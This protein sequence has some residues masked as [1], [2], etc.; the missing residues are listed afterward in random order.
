VRKKIW[1][2]PFSSFL[3]FLELNRVRSSEKDWK[4]GM[5]EYWNIGNPTVLSTIPAFPCSIIPIFF[6]GNRKGHNGS[7]SDGPGKI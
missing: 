2:G 5:M 3:R 1:S 7:P 6:L 4:I